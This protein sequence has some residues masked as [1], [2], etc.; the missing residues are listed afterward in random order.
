MDHLQ[1]GA[2][3]SVEDIDEMLE[4]LEP[5]LEQGFK[6]ARYEPR[7]EEAG[8]QKVFQAGWANYRP[9]VDT[10]WYLYYKSSAWVDPYVPTP[11][12]STGP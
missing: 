9:L 10:M 7:F 5:M 3:W 1:P 6:I 12:E 4:A 8:G 11:D 2:N